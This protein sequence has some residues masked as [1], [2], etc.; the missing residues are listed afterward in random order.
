MVVQITRGP[1][2]IGL[3]LSTSLSLIFVD[4]PAAQADKRLR[5]ALIG[6]GA[7]AVVNGIRNQQNTTRQQQVRRQPSSP[8]RSGNRSASSSPS[9]AVRAV[10]R[11]Q[12][13]LNAMGYDA[14]P[15]DGEPGRRTRDAVL[16]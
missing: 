15:V 16:A 13:A 8:T 7:S 4:V 14:G 5:D 10:M 2:R 12:A 1:M 3:V 6:L 11:E 9:P